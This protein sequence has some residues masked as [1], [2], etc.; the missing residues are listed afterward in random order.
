MPSFWNGTA[1]GTQLKSLV[2]RLKPQ[3][4]I[5][6]TRTPGGP[7]AGPPL[8]GPTTGAPNTGNPNGQI[9]AGPNPLGGPITLT[10]QDSRGGIPGASGGPKP[11]TLGGP[12]ISGGGPPNTGTPGGG[13]LVG[14]PHQWGQPTTSGWGDAPT[15]DA[16]GFKPNFGSSARPVP[17]AAGGAPGA[18]GYG[19]SSFGATDNLIGSQIN[20]TNSALTND[21][22]SAM[23]GALS[24]YMN[25]PLG[26]TFGAVTPGRSDATTRLGGQAQ[27]AADAY[28][29]AGGPPNLSNPAFAGIGANTYGQSQG[30]LQQLLGG[31]AG[32]AGGGSFGYA[33]DTGQA[34]AATMSQLQ[35]M[36]NATP[37]RAALA[38]SAYDRL[39][40]ESQP[41]FE[42][43]LRNV[44]KKAAA[45]G[46]VGSGMT[47]SDLGTVQQRREEQ[48]AARR[49]DLADSAASQTLSDAQSRLSSA[50]GATTGL[51]GMDTAAGNLNLGYLG[52]SNRAIGQNQDSRYR[53]AMG[54]ADLQS[55]S[56]GESVSERDK[57]Y[58]AGQD[59]NNLAMQLDNTRFGR[60]Q[61]QAMDLASLRGNS[62]AEDRALQNDQRTERDFLANQE[63]QTYNRGRQ[64]FTDL[65]SYL[66]GRENQDAANRSWMAQERG[67]QADMDQRAIDN[68]VRERQLQE[69]LLQGRFGRGMDLSQFGYGNQPTGTYMDAAQQGYGVA[70]RYG[71]QASDAWGGA[72]DAVTNWAYNRQRNR[73]PAP[74]QNVTMDQ[75]RNYG[76]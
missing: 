28:A 45:L 55:Q 72:T 37:D 46:R 27:N 18:G 48:L 39:V 21:A 54:L 61:N 2:N 60:L 40:K 22:T 53:A 57:A 64:R 43:D 20:P 9:T 23:S 11:P 56:R 62:L 24:Q 34:R 35:Q 31:G 69:S 76:F 47:T 1:G 65:G 14:F 59:A 5:P 16:N 13:P 50:L 19:L 26:T 44:G 36:L 4:G 58:S 49:A 30:Y 29:G 7:Q 3:T 12:Q 73:A 51:G 17:G 32:Q 38:S 67:Y 52:E 25:Q 42:T 75:W 70:D 71:Q 66:S 10:G 74:P 6:N 33:G 63:N 8:G 41:Q 68:Q 15:F